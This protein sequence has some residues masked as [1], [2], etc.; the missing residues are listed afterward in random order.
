VNRGEEDQ[1]RTTLTIRTHALMFW[2]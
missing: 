2:S 1:P